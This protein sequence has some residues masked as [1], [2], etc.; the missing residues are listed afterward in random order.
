VDGSCWG[1]CLDC[2]GNG[3]ECVPLESAGA[4]PAMGC[5]G[6]S[7]R[8]DLGVL[9]TDVQPCADDSDCVVASADPCCGMADV[10]ILASQ[11]HD[12]LARVGSCDV[13]NPICPD[14]LS[15]PAAAICNGG[16]C[17]VE[18]VGIGAPR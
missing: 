6:P 15:Q 5:G 16:R 3:A 17:E 18:A 10:G 1:E 8:D 13:L 9:C 7:P 11:E 12:F 4:V 14:C 2:G